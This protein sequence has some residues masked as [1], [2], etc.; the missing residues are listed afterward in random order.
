MWEI[1][2]A[3]G[4]GGSP[5][6]VIDIVHGESFQTH[7]FHPFCSLPTHLIHLTRRQ[8]IL[9]VHTSK[10]MITTSSRRILLRTATGIGGRKALNAVVARSASHP[11]SFYSTLESKKAHKVRLQGKWVRTSNL[12]T[13]IYIH[14]T[15]SEYRMPDARPSVRVF[16]CAA[17]R[18]HP[19]V[20]VSSDRPRFFHSEKYR[21]AIR[22][23][24][25]AT[26]NKL[27]SNPPFPSRRIPSAAITTRRRYTR[28]RPHAIGP[29][30]RA[31]ASPDRGPF[32]R[33]KRSR[34]F[35]NTR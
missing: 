20:D 26:V 6:L 4:G 10:A 7:G 13:R 2:S 1:V 5:R 19:P 35:S 25:P 14:N 9:E 30:Y 12:R 27:P 32:T 21:H 23:I 28:D 31:L 22:R 16:R 3:L 33:I 24:S 34:N 8:P 29:G 18:P 15:Y 11:P 17:N